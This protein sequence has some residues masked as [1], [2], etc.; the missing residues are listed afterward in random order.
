METK[1]NTFEE[2]KEIEIEYFENGN[3]ILLIVTGIS[4]TTKGYERKYEKIAKNAIKSHNFSVVVATTPSGSWLHME[5]NLDYI[6]D[7]IQSKRCSDFKIYAMGN[8]AGANLVLWYSYKFPQIKKVLAVNP[9]MNINLH[10]FKPLQYTQKDI[11]V[12]F[13]EFDPSRRF[14]D[15]LPKSKNIRVDVLSNIDHN[16]TENLDLFIALP[17]LYLF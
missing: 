6:M 1:M 4:G 11:N 16:F 15:L 17:N 9:V 2:N 7:Y 14:A 3:D 13:G 10:L 12:V 5:Q 8:S